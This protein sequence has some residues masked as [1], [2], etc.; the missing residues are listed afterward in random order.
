MGK[1]LKRLREWASLAPVALVYGFIFVFGLTL[2]L[3][4]YVGPVVL[5]AWLLWRWLFG[6]VGQ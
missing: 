6:G 4:E 5:V 1:R 3:V 2:V